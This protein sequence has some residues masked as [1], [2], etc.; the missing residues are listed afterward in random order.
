MSEEEYHPLNLEEYR[1][2]FAY[3]HLG[4]VVKARS[5]RKKGFYRRSMVLLEAKEFLAVSRCPWPVAV[6][7]NT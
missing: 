5:N 4:I 3:L 7:R 1:H 2:S 6:S